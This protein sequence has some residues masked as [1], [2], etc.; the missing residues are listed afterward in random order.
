[1]TTINDQKDIE[2]YSASVAAWYG[3]RLEHDKSLLSLSAGGIALLITLITTLGVGSITVLV[4]SISAL[5]SFTLCLICVLTI[6]REN[7][8]YIENMIRADGTIS[9]DR[10]DCLDWIAQGLFIIGVILSVAIAVIAAVSSLDNKGI[11]MTEK[12]KPTTT[13]VLKESFK[14]AESLKPDFTRS[15]SG[16][17]ALKPNNPSNTSSTPNTTQSSTNSTGKK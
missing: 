10:L 12:S 16:A 4:L 1:M 11:S 14:G 17:A 2:H 5:L 7:S 3:T 9:Q 15:F 8:N 6:F 13:T